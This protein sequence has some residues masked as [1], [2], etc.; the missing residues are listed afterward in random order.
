MSIMVRR[1]L[2]SCSTLESQ[3]HI[4]NHIHRMRVPNTIAYGLFTVN[5]T[6]PRACGAGVRT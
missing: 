3:S 4:Y 2:Q 1:R 5:L 6:L